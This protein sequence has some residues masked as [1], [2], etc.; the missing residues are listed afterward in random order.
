MVKIYCI[1][2]ILVTFNIKY[3]MY[4]T[5]KEGGNN[6]SID[7]IDDNCQKHLKIIY[8]TFTIINIIKSY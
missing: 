2:K 7:W 5:C 3:M 4:P 1:Q 6:K 8:V